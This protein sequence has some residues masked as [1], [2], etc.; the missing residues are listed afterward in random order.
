ML[1]VSEIIVR[2]ALERQATVSCAGYAT[3]DAARIATNIVT[4]ALSQ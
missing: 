4:Y 3:E 2:C 1:K